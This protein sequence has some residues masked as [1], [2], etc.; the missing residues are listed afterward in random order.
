[1]SIALEARVK[2]LGV[3]IESYK[4]LVKSRDDEIATLKARRLV[5]SY[6]HSFIGSCIVSLLL[7]CRISQT[8][9]NIDEAQEYSNCCDQQ[10]RCCDEQ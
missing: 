2:E 6:T 4:Q 1:M 9:P 3:L 7:L 10:Q 5:S 8:G